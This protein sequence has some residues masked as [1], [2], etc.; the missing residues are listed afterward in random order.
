MLRI[1]LTPP[2]AVRVVVLE[3]VLLGLVAAWSASWWWRG[4]ALAALVVVAVLV[5]GRWRGREA[6][7]LPAVALA[8]RRRRGRRA[9]RTLR[10]LADPVSSLTVE[11]H[12]DRAGTRFG[13]L[14]G[15][16]SWTSVLAVEAIG[17]DEADVPGPERVALDHLL[18]LIDGHD[19]RCAA[20]QVILGVLP[21]PSPRVDPRSSLAG[22]YREVAAGAAAQRSLLVCLRLEPARCSR[23]VAVR[24]GG[25]RGARRALAAVTARFVAGLDGHAE[26]RVLGPDAVRAAVGAGLG[27]APGPVAENWSGVDHGRDGTQVCYRV[28]RWGTDPAALL[29]DLS[30]LPAVLTAV[31]M[32]FDRDQRDPRVPTILRVLCLPED[33]LTVDSAC[34]DAAR[35]RGAR[36]VRLDGEHALAASWTLPG[37]VPPVAQRPTGPNSTPV[38]P[39]ASQLML[40]LDRGGLAI[41]R[42]HDRR[43]SLLELFQD[44]PAALSALLDPRVVLV[45]GYRALA[46][47]A[48][49][50]VV[51]TRSERWLPLRRLGVDDEEVVAI[52]SPETV[53]LPAAARPDRPHLVIVDL[54][55]YRDLPQV[56]GRPWQAVLTVLPELAMRD[57]PAARARGPVLLRRLDRREA[58]AAVPFLGLPP[59]TD[60]R[61]T[62]LSDDEFAVVD[63]GRMAVVDLSLTV[64]ESQL[65]VTATGAPGGSAGAP[66]SAAPAGSA[67]DA[68]G[69][70]VHA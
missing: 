25:D 69:P 17:A 22:S 26:V 48:R 51:S 42:G 37:R 62:E 11:A 64:P 14:R 9:D 46:V 20:V 39:W 45:L 49:I 36:L 27:V 38:P 40:P 21:S 65:V 15:P 50:S 12:A 66:V 23:A 5:L 41:G 18:G 13:L 4:P 56:P 19:D 60:R 28:T 35:T 3:A 10:L 30:S 47:G 7:A 16:S 58:I 57:L 33:R 31:S 68:T 43:A 34:R 61:L 67:G 29:A 8:Y 44:R 70:R 32:T 52:F 6:R 63:R 1:R 2:G 54:P 59:G 24:G 53:R 55:G